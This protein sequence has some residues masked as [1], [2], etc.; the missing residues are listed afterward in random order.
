M[1][2]AFTIAGMDPLVLAGVALVAFVASIVGGVSGYGGGLILPPVLAPVVG[3]AA[4]VP[5]MSI[6]MAMTNAS[7]VAAFRHELSWRAILLVGAGMA[8]FCLLSAY[9]YTQLPVRA[10]AAMLG[11]FLI[12]S[13]PI[14]RKLD[15]TGW[16]LSG[17]GAVAGGA[18]YG[19]IVGSMTGVGPLLLSLMM[20]LGL[21]GGALI[22]SEAVVSMS[23]SLIKASVFG[24]ATLIDLELLAA[25]ILIG[26][27]TVPGA[28]VARW[29]LKRF[30]PRV[31]LVM[32]DALVIAGGASFLWRAWTG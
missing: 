29:M 8:P 14:R 21:R 22:G 19:A 5:V 32:M 16:H 3:V 6:A 12:V 9:V 20:G 15:K 17:G 25:G 10:I 30:S 23:G 4:V 27:A 1:E 11:V 31:H 24:S 13:V 26:L 18:V 2:S 28:F 7:R